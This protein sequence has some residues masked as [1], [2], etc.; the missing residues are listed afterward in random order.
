MNGEELRGKMFLGFAALLVLGFMMI[1]WFSH[2]ESTPSSF[3]PPVN[4][5]AAAELS[6][7]IRYEP[8]PE[9][10]EVGGMVQ[11]TVVWTDRTRGTVDCVCSGLREVC[12]ESL[13]QEFFERHPGWEPGE[14][15]LL[16]KGTCQ[17]CIF[18]QEVQ[19]GG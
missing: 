9:G 5:Q 11:T 6:P 3:A 4:L 19:W 14:D 18:Q 2:R 10:M 16:F 12:L 1:G 7:A 15:A 17:P 13:G 8:C